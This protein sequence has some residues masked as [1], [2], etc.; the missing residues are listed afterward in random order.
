MLELL[1]DSFQDADEVL[2]DYLYTTRRRPDLED[3]T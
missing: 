3:N 1:F 2:K